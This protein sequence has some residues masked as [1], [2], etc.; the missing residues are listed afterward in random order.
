[1]FTHTENFAV[2]FLG[3]SQGY[4]LF[5]TQ[6]SMIEIP[7]WILFGLCVLLGLI[8]AALEVALFCKLI[9]QKK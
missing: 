7:A 3:C 8:L 5:L 1:M 9:K 6:R 2:M 4:L